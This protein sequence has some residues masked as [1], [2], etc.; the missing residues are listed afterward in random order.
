MI[1]TSSPCQYHW[2]HLWRHW[3]LRPP[4]VPWT[5]DSVHLDGRGWED[6]KFAFPT[7]SPVMQMLLVQ[8]QGFKIFYMRE[9]WGLELSTEN[10]LIFSI[11]KPEL[12]L[13]SREKPLILKQS[14][15]PRA[16]RRRPVPWRERQ[17]SLGLGAYTVAHHL[18][19]SSHKEPDSPIAC[20]DL[21]GSHIS[22]DA[23]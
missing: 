14:L 8:R 20:T 1:L 10:L 22:W 18:G 17:K 2:Q 9:M 4:P 11:F 16:D 12:P 13:V 6:W 15:G 3:L 19:T 23:V 21:Q 5:Y 7:S